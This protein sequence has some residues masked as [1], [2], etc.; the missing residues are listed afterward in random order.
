VS[1]R[2]SDKHGTR[3]DEEMKHETRGLE[4]GAPVEPRAEESRQQ[5]AAAEGQ[6]APDTRPQIETL[7]EARGEL[8]RHVEPSVFP[9]DKD[10]LLAS[11]SRQSA[12]QDVMATL[13]RLPD[14]K[15][16]QTFEEVWETLGG[17]N[18]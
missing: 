14:G 1:D 10:G 7:G 9:T 2:G 15:T 12:P 11:A 8:A 6:P 5:E 18:F 16:F 17:P 13:A 4:Q 3:I